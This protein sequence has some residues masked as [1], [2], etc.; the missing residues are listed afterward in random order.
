M[1][2]SR[3]SL[4]AFVENT[5]T[6]AAYQAFQRAVLASRLRHIAQSAGDMRTVRILSAVKIASIGTAYSISPRIIR[7]AGDG[8][9]FVSVRLRNHRLHLPV[10]TAREVLGVRGRQEASSAK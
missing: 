5:R 4:A 1:Q 10:D 7:T 2:N 6:S 9:M 8:S 3:F